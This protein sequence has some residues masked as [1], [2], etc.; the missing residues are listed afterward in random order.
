LPILFLKPLSEIFR[1]FF[2]LKI[3]FRICFNKDEQKKSKCLDI[4]YLD[5]VIAQ[6]FIYLEIKVYDI[7]N[8]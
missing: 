5:N 1:G 7:I 2:V 6:I 3:I 4:I 8:N